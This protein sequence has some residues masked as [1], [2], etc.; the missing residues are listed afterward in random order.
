MEFCFQVS[1]DTTSCSYQHF[2][3]NSKE[4]PV[5]ELAEYIVLLDHPFNRRLY[6][7]LWVSTYCTHVESFHRYG[8]KEQFSYVFSLCLTACTPTTGL[9]DVTNNCDYSIDVFL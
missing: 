1:E 2:Y 5:T 7:S 3:L 9:I 6:T 4:Y 8:G